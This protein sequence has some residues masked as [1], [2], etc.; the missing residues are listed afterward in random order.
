MLTRPWLSSIASA[1]RHHARRLV[2]R[3]CSQR[4]PNWLRRGHHR[5]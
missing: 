2:S 1:C 5:L 4:Y 3:W